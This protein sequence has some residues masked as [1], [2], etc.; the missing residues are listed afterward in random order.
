MSLLGFQCQIDT[1]IEDTGL[2]KLLIGFPMPIIQ[3]P[4]PYLSKVPNHTELVDI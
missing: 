2:P 1:L 4:S 3:I